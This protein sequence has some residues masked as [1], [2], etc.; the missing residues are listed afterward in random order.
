MRK[1]LRSFLPMFAAILLLCTALTTTAFAAG[2]P[3]DEPG[4][5]I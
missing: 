4:T 1:H 2:D 5:K 3:T